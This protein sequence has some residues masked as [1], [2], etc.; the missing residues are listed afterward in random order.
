MIAN[1]ARIMTY[2]LVEDND[3]HAEIIERCLGHGKQSHRI[4][5]TKSGTACLNYL[6]AQEE[7]SDREQFPYPDVVL[8][9]IRMPGTLDGL[10]TLKSIRS[11][12]R[13]RSLLVMMLTTSDRDRDVSRA[14][15]LGANGYIVKSDDTAEMIDRLLQMHWAFTGLV[16]LPQRDLSQEHVPQTPVEPETSLSADIKPL[17]QSDEDA[18]LETLSLY[19]R[20]RYQEFFELLD[21][22]EDV[23]VGRFLRLSSRFCQECRNL[24]IRVHGVDWT[25]IRRVVMEKLPPYMTPDEMASIVA[26][27]SAALEGQ[28]WK[29]SPPPSWHAWKG[30]SEAFLNLG[31]H[32]PAES[33]Q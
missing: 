15:E 23:N 10:Q 4:Q 20:E 8:L 18:A 31:R 2:L 24:F 19:Y 26:S 5:R 27:I 14:Y 33:P 13:H 11:D 1:P 3:D 25:I 9:D 21:E 32:F 22:L 28:V 29:G 17:M 7:F 16:E 6:A 30:F 12:P